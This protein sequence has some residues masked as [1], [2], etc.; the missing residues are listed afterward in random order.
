MKSIGQS[1]VTEQWNIEWKYGIEKNED[2]TVTIIK[3]LKFVVS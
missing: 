2:V 3:K 1:V